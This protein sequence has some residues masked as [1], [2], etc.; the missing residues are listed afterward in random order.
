MNEEKYK[1]KI[2]K[3]ILKFSKSTINEEDL[4]EIE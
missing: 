3:D 2:L 1:L 4:K